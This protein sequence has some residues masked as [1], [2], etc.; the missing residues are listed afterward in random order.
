MHQL[1]DAVRCVFSEPRLPESRH[2]VATEKACSETVSGPVEKVRYYFRKKLF[3]TT[4][5]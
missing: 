3:S 5:L 4:S 2:I 1:K